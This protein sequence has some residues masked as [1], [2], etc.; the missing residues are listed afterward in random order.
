MYPR[1]LTLALAGAFALAGLS[2]CQSC[3]HTPAPVQSYCP[4]CVDQIQPPPARMV[5]VPGPGPI[6][7]PAPATYITPAPERRPAP[8]EIGTPVPPAPL[9][10]GPNPPPADPVPER[11]DAGRAPSQNAKEPPVASVPNKPAPS[12][13]E[14]RETPDPIDIPSYTLAVPNVASGLKPFPDGI[15]WL[16]QRGFKTVLHLRQP[17]EDDTAVRR[18]FEKKGFR[19]ISLEASPARLTKELYEQFTRQVT[20]TANHPLYVFDKDRSVASGLWYLYFRVHLKQSD[21][22]ARAEAQRLGLRFDEDTEHKAMWLAV[23]TLLKK[24]EP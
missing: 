5:P 24:L 3:C 12:V 19:F 8:A 1:L 10:N 21:E 4:T 23:Q 11:R 22:K 7:G 18:L 13:D 14:H 20:D 16:K 17:G 15:D 9:P 2:G 6:E